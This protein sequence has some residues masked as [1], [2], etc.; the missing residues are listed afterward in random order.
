MGLIFDSCVSSQ[1]TVNRPRDTAPLKQN[2]SGY[3]GA[4]LNGFQTLPSFC[5]AM[6]AKKHSEVIRLKRFPRQSE[7]RLTNP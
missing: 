2:Q 5:S 4:V 1:R 7:N 6:Q 3:P